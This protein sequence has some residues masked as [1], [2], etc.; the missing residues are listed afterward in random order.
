MDVLEGRD[1]F[2]LLSLPKGDKR[3]L[4]VNFRR[5][6]IVS[7]R[8]QLCAL[9][10]SV[11]CGLGLVLR[12]TVQNVRAHERIFVSVARLHKIAGHG[13]HVS[14]RALVFPECDHGSIRRPDVLFLLKIRDVFAIFQHHGNGTAAVLKK[15]N[16]KSVELVL[17]A[18]LIKN[19]SCLPA[20]KRAD[21]QHRRILEGTVCD[22]VGVER[23]RAVRRGVRLERIQGI[24]CS[25]LFLTRKRRNERQPIGDMARLYREL[26]GDRLCDRV[27]SKRLKLLAVVRYCA[28]LPRYLQ[29]IR[30]D[31][32]H[33][34]GHFQLVASVSLFCHCACQRVGKSA[35]SVGFVF[36][37]CLRVKNRNHIVQNLGIISSLVT[38]SPSVTVFSPGSSCGQSVT[39]IKLLRL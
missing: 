6:D 33:W 4:Y 18:E 16:L 38:L 12:R 36:C 13:R 23:K 37:F 20:K 11:F 1:V 28:D 32:T 3:E 35:E 14:V 15:A 19:T 30:M 10:E 27:D 21:G 25:R 29:V 7:F 39:S 2:V 31:A 22:H 8:V 5:A 24:L 34:I 9:R 26:S 17:A